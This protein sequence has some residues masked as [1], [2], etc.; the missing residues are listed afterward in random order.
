M[1]KMR[2]PCDKEHQAWVL[3]Y[4]RKTI[5]T[6]CYTEPS[7]AYG[8]RN[9]MDLPGAKFI[10]LAGRVLDP[11]EFTFST[12]QGPAVETKSEAIDEDV[13]MR[14]PPKFEPIQMQEWRGKR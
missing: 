4:D 8:V 6:L 14:P 12:S 10:S 5:R 7:T 11:Y 13:E 3:S 2:S 1:N 9:N